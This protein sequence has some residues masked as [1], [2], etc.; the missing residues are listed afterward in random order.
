VE[1]LAASIARKAVKTSNAPALTLAEARRALPVLA[2]MPGTLDK[3]TPVDRV[4]PAQTPTICVRKMQ[5]GV[6]GEV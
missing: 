6:V 4:Y 3:F 5:L 2:Q 1:A